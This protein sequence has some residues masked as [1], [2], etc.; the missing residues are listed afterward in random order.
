MHITVVERLGILGGSI[1][2]G[3]GIGV[4]TGVARAGAEGVVE[5]TPRARPIIKLRGGTTRRRGGV[6]GWRRRRCGGWRRSGDD[7]TR[8]TFVDGFVSPLV[9]IDD[10]HG[11]TAAQ[12]RSVGLVSPRARLIVA[13]GGSVNHRV[14]AGN[15]L[16]AVF[17]G[18]CFR[19]VV[20]CNRVGAGRVTGGSGGGFILV[21]VCGV[22]DGHVRFG[23]SVAA[24]IIFR[25]V[26][27]S[28]LVIHV[29]RIFLFQG[30]RIAN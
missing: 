1:V 22:V 5:S 2:G 10:V 16:A 14:G 25:G 23:D 30:C 17:A 3:R 13:A 28:I 7:A 9:G 24:F 27:L 20:R 18:Y 26:A 6:G 8:Y 15:V 12:R 19:D 21:M 29:S 4:V 11:V